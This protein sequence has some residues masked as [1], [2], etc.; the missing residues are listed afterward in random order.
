MHIQDGRLLFSKPLIMGVLNL[1]PDSFYD[2]GFF[3]TEKQQ[4]IQV[5]KML[6]EGADIIDIGAVSSRPGALDIS[7]IDEIARIKP[8]L[9]A[10]LKAFGHIT[11]SVD[12]YR[13]KVALMAINEG[14]SIINDISAGQLDACMFDTVL[15]LQVPYIMM[16]MKGTPQTMQN[17]PIYI[18]VVEEVIQYLRERAYNLENKGVNGII[19]DPG[20]GFG[21][22]VEQNYQMMQQLE[23]F[24]ELGFPLLVGISR[25]SMIYKTLCTSPDSAL[26]GTTVLNTIALIKGADILRVHDVKE[27]VECVKLVLAVN[28]RS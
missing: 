24:K 18:N 17:N 2:G 12:T 9:A 7:E 6:T 25:K 11:I 8:L 21:K 4:L 13:S 16:H 22:T 5:E 20:F 19:I 23:K 14:A 15:K 27:A 28:N 3:S 1:T 26:N 10:I